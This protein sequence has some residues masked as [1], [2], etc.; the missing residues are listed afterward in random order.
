MV[1]VTP[2]DVL[3]DVSMG[4]QLLEALTSTTVQDPEEDTAKYTDSMPATLASIS[5]LSKDD[6]RLECPPPRIIS[7]PIP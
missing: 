2:C 3:Q 1:S 7:S 4:L 5:F 6:E